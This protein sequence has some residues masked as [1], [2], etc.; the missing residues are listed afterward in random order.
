M[1]TRVLALF[2]MALF[3]SSC[4]SPLRPSNSPP[5]KLQVEPPE[6][7]ASQEGY[8]VAQ[9]ALVIGNNAYEYKPL[10]NPL[11]DA[12]DVAQSLTKLGFNVTLKT[13]LD[14]EG[15]EKAIND[16][17]ER[18]R[19]TPKQ[20]VGIFYFSGHGAQVKGENF[21]FP[22]NNG[23]TDEDNLKDEA[24]PANRISNMMKVANA[25]GMNIITLDACR[26]N[27]YEGSHKNLTKGL[28][29]M[30]PPTPRSSTVVA[31]A[32]APGKTASDE[33]PDGRHGMY[34]YYLLNALNNPTS[35]RIDEVFEGVRE[36]VHAQTGQEPFFHASLRMYCYL[37][38]KCSPP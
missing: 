17:E 27:P 26:D 24:I 15:M 2:S 12:N 21:L 4:Q 36:V 18:L 9:T 32:T 6:I 28:A 7:N 38:G 5:K 8:S 10:E 29:R 3:V 19:A 35:K 33:G 1:M 13:N 25:G 31:F 30:E 16:F 20:D 37:G 22:I 14:F 34:T 11:N 23:G